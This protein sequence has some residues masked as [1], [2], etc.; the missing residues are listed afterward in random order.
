MGKKTWRQD[1]I[2]IIRHDFPL[3]FNYLYCPRPELIT[4]N[5]LWG[6]GKIA[7]SEGAIF[8]KIDL[9][10]ELRDINYQRPIYESPSIQPRKTII[11]DLAKSE[12][13]LL[14]AMHEKT[15]Y[16]I[17]LAEKKGVRIKN[18]QFS[19]PF[20]ARLAPEHG[21][22]I[23]NFQKFWELLQETAKRD[24]FHTHE[25]QYYEKLLTT[26]SENFSN[27]LFFAEYNDKVLAAVL[28]NFY[29][30]Q[31]SMGIA[32]Y[33]HGASLRQHK[34]VMAPHLLHWRLIQEAKERGFIKY[35]FWGID[36]KRWPGLTRFKIGFGGY[37]V[38]Y[39]PSMDV[40][41]KPVWY[42]AY[43]WRRR[44]KATG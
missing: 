33:L 25:K 29:R 15:R 17:R 43:C 3:G 22:A 28:V 18:F 39:P 1:D 44:F 23:S 19:R 16:N 4:D 30:G 9:V 31:T 40:V 10:G 37:T 38:E 35:D 42:R 7:E 32:T 5:W 11:I 26:R 8:L 2:F 12:D 36:E 20:E 6:A 14:L 41:Y 21:A 27:E 34:E 24:N 13:D